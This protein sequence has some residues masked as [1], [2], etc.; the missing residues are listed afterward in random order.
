M[1]S[2]SFG[3]FSGLATRHSVM[4]LALSMKG[5]D[6]WEE[7]EGGTRVACGENRGVEHER[8]PG[9]AG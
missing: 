2:V 6:A 4:E 1:T 7:V 5:G 9:G 3:R 8:L